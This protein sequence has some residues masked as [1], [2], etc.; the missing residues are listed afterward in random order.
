MT[1]TLL[2]EI[3]EWSKERPAWQR[4]A[5]RRLFSSGKVDSGGVD[6]LV[7]LCKVAHGLSDPRA[8]QVLTTEQLPV[9]DR[10]SDTVTLTSITHNH[11]VNALAPDQ[12]I[13][14]GPN[15]TLVYGQNAAGK[16]GYTRILKRACRSR[17]TE[18]ILG[19]VL[20]GAVPL[21]AQAT[22][23]YREG[24]REEQFI[25]T[26]DVVPNS[27]LGAVSVFD[28]FTAPIY[29]RDKTDVA[30]RPFCLDVFDKLSAVC[31]EV[32][33]R[34]ESEYA[35]LNTVVAKLPV[36]AEGTRAHSF[37][38]RITS[39]TN[40]DELRTLATLTP[41]EQRTL[42]DLKH[43]QR[44]LQAADPKQRAR[45]LDLKAER[46]DLLANHVTSLVKALGHEGIATLRS[47]ADSL[48]K[49]RE[50]LAVLR[51]TALSAGLLPGSG[52]EVWRSMWDAA[53]RFSSVAYPAAPFPAIHEGAVCPFC[54]QLIG[55]DAAKRLEHFAEYVSSN[56]QADVR[57]AEAA[58]SRLV[59]AIAQVSVKSPEIELATNELFADDAELGGRLHGL[60]QDAV[61]IQQA[62]KSAAEVGSYPKR[63]LQ[64]GIESDL[65]SAAKKLRDRAA[66]LKQQSP[67][68]DPPAAANLR[69]LE[70][71]AALGEHLQG[72]VD[73][74]E[75]QKRLAAYQQCINDTQ[76]GPIT[77]K[78]T[79]L[80]K[81]LITD[82]L[83][84]T[85][86]SELS[87]LEF[88]HLAVEI[89]AAGGAR[90]ALFHRLAFTNAPGVA[91]PEV[92]SEGESRT[93]SLAAFLTELSTAS[94][95]SAIVFDDPVSSLDHEW[96]E[97]I[98]RRLLLE[99][100]ERQVIVF[101]HDIVFLRYLLDEASKHEVA[102]LNQYVRREGQAGISSPDLPWFAMGI[103]ERIG[104]LRKL[105]QAAEK[106]LRTTG[107]E[108]YEL[109]ARDIYARLR[110]AWEQATSETLLNDVVQRY[111]HSIETRK[112][113]C[114]DDITEADCRAVEEAMTEGSRWMRGHDQPAADAAP[115]PRPPELKLRIDELAA[116]VEAIK[117]RRKK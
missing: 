27:A 92:V 54:Q 34:L 36:L 87:K 33:T 49:A 95:K 17:G 8:A 74:V 3:L 63:E 51:A 110:E 11:G 94:G 20:T 67:A 72:V 85:F 12:T 100:K 96:R 22:I 55:S 91:V 24:A 10:A 1:D 28:G 62:A 46:V 112:V 69:E 26:P 29:V 58:Y 16:S 97:R 89:Q 6:E 93:L 115:V 40:V 60:L 15:L 113:K 109:A 9:T 104:D 65:S 23:R 76:T 31:G 32:R 14:F 30:F 116:F 75:R 61:L 101:T 35:K 108:T 111:R 83:R 43:Q 25:W 41:E 13:T 47:A 19:D 80:T 88:D 117:T 44:D 59:S 98:A 4:D 114:L 52:E 18:V 81:R 90:G 79:E 107:P 57:G 5:L 39:L 50:I 48:R 53:Q 21:K 86:R 7:V 68:L 103:K 70:A 78:S 45:E 66:T 106:L 73:E 99:A 82:E 38:T 102:C 77:R 71:R 56:A 42:T 105:W 64:A 37:T 84:A 2:A